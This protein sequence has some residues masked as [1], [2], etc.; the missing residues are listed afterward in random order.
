[1]AYEL[2]Q[3]KVNRF[4]VHEVPQKSLKT[5]EDSTIQPILSEVE[6]V[7]DQKL[8]NFFRQRIVNAI[9][10]SN[11]FNIKFDNNESVVPSLINDYFVNQDKLVTI[12]REVA[13]HLFKIQNAKNSGG[14]LALADGTAEAS[15]WVAILKIEKQDGVTLE[16][17]SREGKQ[18][19][20]VTYLEDLFFTKKTKLF[21]IALFRKMA[22]SKEL[23]A[24]ASDYQQSTT[25]NNEIAL[26]FLETFLGCKLVISPE[27][28]TKLF[29][30]L[31]QRFINENI[32][33]TPE[34][35]NAYPGLLAEILNNSD[36]IN[37]IHF[38]RNTF[39]PEDRDSYDA[40]LKENGFATDS[41][42]KDTR[43][44]KS[45]VEQLIYTLDSGLRIIGSE[46]SVNES[47]NFS[48][49]EQG[50][51]FLTARGKVAGV[52]KG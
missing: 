13:S 14:L 36:K 27:I 15:S 23:E 48:R 9:T 41:F 25:S 49:D 38:A 7:L 42:Q 52:G 39:S 43:L 21:K 29:F 20:D 44:V 40:Y 1:M 18:T 22:V 34:V 10:S 24:R 31:T 32:D 4:I 16:R 37:P 45:K 35:L 12:S 28:S 3:C 11:A 17:K 47:V 46:E 50:D 2:R 6:S 26:F 8:K 19:F 5:S 33:K 51:E 30:E